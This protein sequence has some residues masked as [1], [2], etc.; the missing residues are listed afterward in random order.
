MEKEYRIK[1]RSDGVQKRINER[2]KSS[3]NTIL[4]RTPT[5]GLTT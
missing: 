4:A 2:R 1:N 3:A 5:F